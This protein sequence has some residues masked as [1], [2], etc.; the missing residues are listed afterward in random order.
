MPILGVCLGHQILAEVY[1]GKTRRVDPVHGRLS[2]IRHNG[3]P[4]FAEIPSGDFSMVR[5]HSLAVDEN[6]LADCLQPIAWTQ[7]KT[8]ALRGSCQI[9]NDEDSI[10]MGLAH[11]DNPHYGVQFHP[12]SIGSDFGLQLFKNFRKLTQLHYNRLPTE[13]FLK[14]V[15]RPLLQSQSRPMATKVVWKECPQP[16]EL[17]R[18]NL[19]SLFIHFTDSTDLEDTFWLDRY[20]HAIS[21]LCGKYGV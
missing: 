2:R 13:V 9:Q 12:E 15:P 17:N 20:L 14:D 3:N 4:L 18:E 6:T 16:L 5:Y 7:G 21:K 10:L 19:D 8:H 1:G 11:V